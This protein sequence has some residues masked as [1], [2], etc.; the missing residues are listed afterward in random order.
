MKSELRVAHL[1][2]VHSRHD[3]RIFYKECSSLARAGYDISLL[4]ADGLGNEVKNG[5]RIVDIGEKSGRIDR[6][7]RVGLKMYKK[8]LKLN[9]DIYHFHDPE[10]MPIGLLLKKNGKK[11]IFDSHEDVPK[12][13][14]SKPYLTPTILKGLARILET[15]ENSVCPHFAAIVAATPFIRD[16]FLKINP[17]SVD[18]NNYP[19][20]GELAS[21]INWS[22]KKNEVCYVGGIN[23]IRGVVE[24]VKAG[25]YLK[26]DAKINLAGNFSDSHHRAEVKCLSGWQRINEA[27]FLNRSEVNTLMKK[28]CAGI[29]SF[30]P[31][32]NHVDAQPN[33]MFEYMSAG[34]PVIASNFPLWREI[35]EGNN[36]GICVDP[37]K[38]QE[39]A[40]AID[41]IIE[42]PKEAETM[43]NNGRKAVLDK[44]NWQIEQKKLLKIYCDLFAK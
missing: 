44:Y 32:P 43:G 1:T 19:I 18:I 42:H 24:M 35:I 2:S 6:M 34:L 5:V 22:E 11:V 14:L 21:E 28:S 38:P 13:T 8:A 29:V 16:K 25:E 39:I 27:G 31:E 26:S 37:L 23:K 41:W 30:L 36:S 3:T 4:V 12:Q 33:K 7:T 9:A 17:N 10:L 40:K 20:L 15:I